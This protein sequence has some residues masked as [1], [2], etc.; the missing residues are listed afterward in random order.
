[1][2][3]GADRRRVVMLILRR[4]MRLTGWGLASGLAATFAFGRVMAGLVFG[5][6][7]DDAVTLVAVSLFLAGVAFL[8]SYIPARRAASVDP[9]V[10]LR[11][12]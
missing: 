1:M 12:E 5:V 6:A 11:S 8:A 9:V 2:A 4:A 10:A 3:L 7:T